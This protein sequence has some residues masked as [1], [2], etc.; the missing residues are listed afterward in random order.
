MYPLFTLRSEAKLI[1][2]GF[3]P[4]ER[5]IRPGIVRPADGLHRLRIHTYLL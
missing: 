5:L 2:S 1:G 4:T 3:G